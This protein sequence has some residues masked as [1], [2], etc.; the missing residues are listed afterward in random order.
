MAPNNGRTVPAAVQPA[1]NI[2]N[3]VGAL[4]ES[5]EELAEDALSIG[6]FQPKSGGIVDRHRKERA[7]REA[8]EHEAENA[9]TPVEERSYKAVKVAQVQPEV[10]SINLVTIAAG[11]Q[12]M[13]APNSPYRA[14]VS[15]SII[16]TVTQPSTFTQP[17][18]PASTVAV[19][20]TSNQP[21]TV[22]IS[23]GTATVTTVNGVVVGGGDGTYVVPAYGS[24]AVTYSVAPTW[25]W[26]VI[27]GTSPTV[28]FA[29]LNV[30]KDANQALGG[31]SFPIY[32]G[33]PPLILNSR[34]QVYA[35]NPGTTPVQVAVLS[36]IYGPENAA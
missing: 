15:F 12:A 24:I 31:V 20:N 36:E 34:A 3:G 30:A 32:A 27:P 23:G 33:N 25:T 19:Q 11:G 10:T 2:N 4:V 26:T 9:A 28:A 35:F 18:V 5:V 29:Q 17:A 7:R 21:Y 1:I 22:V 13:I 6:D 14:R 8:A 16:P